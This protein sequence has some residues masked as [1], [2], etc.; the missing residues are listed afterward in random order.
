MST[1]CALKTP[2]LGT[3]VNTNKMAKIK[4]ANR[5]KIIKIIGWW[6][7]LDGLLSIYYLSLQSGTGLDFAFLVRFIRAGIGLYLLVV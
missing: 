4:L 3:R 1:T 2:L 6:L 7:L 5:K